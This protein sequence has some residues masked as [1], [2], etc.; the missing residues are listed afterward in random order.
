MSNI[1]IDT[2]GSG[3]LMEG[4]EREDNDLLKPIGWRWSWKLKCLYLPRN[5]RPET[6]NWKVKQTIEALAPREVTV[7]G[8]QESDEERAV[9]LD[10]RDRDLVDV[11][12]SKAERASAQGDAVYE[13]FK[14]LQ[15]MIPMGQPILVGHH[16]EGRH[17]RHLEKIDRKL[18]KAVEAWGEGRTEA[19]LSESAAARVA[20]REKKAA[21]DEYGPDDINVGDIINTTW[22]ETALVM[23]VSAKSVTI[24]S[25]M[26]GLPNTDALPYKRVL[27]VVA[28]ATDGSRAVVKK[29][30]AQ[31]REYRAWLKRPERR[32]GDKFTP[33]VVLTTDPEIDIDA[34]ALSRPLNGGTRA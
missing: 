20:A 14:S 16:S 25:S 26:L 31:V 13:E 10:Q 12:A 32:L 4:T 29:A 28:E 6:V 22:Q 18:G 17:R 2:S 1:T 11:H 34:L 19:G 9:R 15:D 30:T 21:G 27:G 5:L 3:A 7:A 23:R 8:E 24:P 33:T